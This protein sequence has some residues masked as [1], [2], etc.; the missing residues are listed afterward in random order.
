MCRA[1][2]RTFGISVSSHIVADVV[3]GCGRLHSLFRISICRATYGYCSDVC[4]LV[5][6]R[7]GEAEGHA[8]GQVGQTCPPVGLVAQEHEPLV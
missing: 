4:G 6:S 2:K 7:V 5:D 3:G 8:Q 1:L